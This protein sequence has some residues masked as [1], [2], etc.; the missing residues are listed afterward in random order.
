MKE[1]RGQGDRDPN[2]EYEELAEC[3]TCKGTRHELLDV[4]LRLERLE[5]EMAAIIDTLHSLHS[6]E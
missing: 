6:L 2:H 1:G 5:G 3:G 4:E